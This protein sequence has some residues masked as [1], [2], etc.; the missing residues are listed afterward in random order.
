MK[1]NNGYRIKYR[2]ELYKN[3][4]RIQSTF[5]SKKTKIVR[6]SQ[7]TPYENGIL[8][9]MLGCGRNIINEAIFHNSVELRK[10]LSVLSEKS[11]IEYIGGENA[12]SI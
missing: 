11:L 6:C 5:S 9:V 12:N 1:K 2:I 3:G 8:K 10:T 4:Q 7:V